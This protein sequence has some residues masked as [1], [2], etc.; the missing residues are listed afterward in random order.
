MQ[1]SLFRQL[2]FETKRLHVHSLGFVSLLLCLLLCGCADVF[3][4]AEQ[5]CKVQAAKGLKQYQSEKYAD[6]EQT[7]LAATKLAK[8]SQNAL[9]QPLMLRELARCYSAQKK[10][11]QAEESLQ[12]ALACYE[13]LQKQAHG[14]RFDQSVVDER[15]YETL[16]SLADSCLAQNQLPEAKDA[17]AQ[18]IALGDKIVEPPTISNQVK[19]NY[20]NVLEKSGDKELAYNM[21]RQ[22]DAATITMDEFDQRFDAAVAALSTG[23]YEQAQ[24]EFDT[25]QLAADGFLGSNQRQ[26][27]ILTY[28]AL[29]KIIHNSPAEAELLAR[30]AVQIAETSRD[31][32]Y[33]DISNDYTLSG[34]AAELQG[35][36]TFSDISY[37]KAFRTEPYH[38]RHILLTAQKGLES[39][40]YKKQAQIVAARIKSFKEDPRFVLNPKV[41]IE[42]VLLA[43]EQQIDG[44]V[45]LAKETRLKGLVHL[46]HESHASEP[47][48][49]RGAY[50]LYKIYSTRGEKGLADRALKQMRLVGGRTESGQVQ[51]K[52]ALRHEGLG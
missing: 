13:E 9:Q 6:A 44:K 18:A 30:R 46:E 29:M 28:A 52:K 8:K 10:Y 43:R 39:F 25:L 32:L 35:G 1:L 5:K 50:Q 38:P 51:L 49:L 45:A 33:P 41:A 4:D 37:L 17:Y 19:Q 48:E 7:Y 36:T 15:Q 14:T 27:R 40:G 21:Q 23:D 31:P 2:S 47:G 34:L 3:V 12:Q 24:K 42:Y 20:V 16:A 26:G 11:K 22:L